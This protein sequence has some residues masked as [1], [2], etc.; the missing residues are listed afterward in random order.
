LPKTK[1]PLPEAWRHDLLFLY[2]VA[3]E[4]SQRTGD[5]CGPL[6]EAL[7]RIGKRLATELKC[8]VEDLVEKRDTRKES[9][10]EKQV[11][12]NGY[13]DSLPRPGKCCERN[14]D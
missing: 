2:G 1:L 7:E 3:M 14:G 10:W 6:V 8:K 13:R 4:Q 12:L 9:S 11:K 5:Y